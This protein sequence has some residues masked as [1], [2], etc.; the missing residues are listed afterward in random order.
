M[1]EVTSDISNYK[2]IL[3]VFGLE[4][5][6]KTMS[7]NYGWCISNKFIVPFIIRKKYF[8]KFLSFTNQTIYLD[9]Y[10]EQDEEIFLNEAIHYFKN[11][12]IDFITQAPTNAIFR[13]KPEGSYFCRFGTYQIDLNSDEN[14]LF[15]RVHTK[16]RNVIRKAAKEGVSIERGIHLSDICYQIINDTQ[17]RNGIAFYNYDDYLNFVESLR[18]NVAFFC[19]FKDGICQGAAIMLYTTEGAYYVYG[20][21]K[22][23]PYSGSMNLLQWEAMKYFKQKGIKSYDFLGAR[24][25]SNIDERKAGIQK[26]KERF[27]G[28]LKTGFLW[29]YDIHPIKRKLYYYMIRLKYGKKNKDIIDEENS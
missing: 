20:G 28:E 16:H 8:F 26:F 10:T 17:I 6:L 9:N 13:V 12:G 27:G 19:A 24:L 2:D 21:S 1:F 11:K 25:S 14:V 18:N 22:E 23:H 15:E 7:D 29:K 3:P 4:C 5:Y